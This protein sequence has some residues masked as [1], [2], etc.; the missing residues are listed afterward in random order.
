MSVPSHSGSP[1][2]P[3]SAPAWEALL[4]PGAGPLR[5]GFLAAWEQGELPGLRARPLLVPGGGGPLAAAPAYLYDLDMSSV[6]TPVLPEVVAI[7]RRV[8]PRFLVSRVLELGAPSARVH[9][10]LF[11]AGADHR[12]A[13]ATLLRGAVSV[14]AQEGAAM[15]VVQ[16]HVDDAAVVAALRAAGFARVRTL[17]T[18]VLSLKWES[19]EG[20][21]SAMRH[22]YRRRARVVMAAS[23]HLRVEHVSGFEAAASEMARLWRRVYERA[24]E[25]RREVLGEAFFAA[26][27]R[28]DYISALMLRREDESL[29]A[30]GLLM[31]DRPCLHFLQC[32]FE[33]RAGREEAAYFRLLLEIA[34]HAIENGYAEVNLGCT[35]LGPKLD[36]GAV[37]VELE[38]WL[39]HRHRTL[40]GLFTAGGNGRFAPPRMEPRRVFAEPGGPASRPVNR[41]GSKEDVR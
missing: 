31:D 2:S 19:F 8:W 40:Q 39:R 35:T 37:P 14:A 16:D 41:R 21:L 23:R 3:P 12:T 13:S 20:Y 34:R 27:A 28:L 33:E 22:K 32:G 36:L 6:S 26:A 15:I 9:P 4:G 24:R 17:P 30:F 7:V 11:G 18:A 1:S 38:A 29:A 25:T 5:G 10:F